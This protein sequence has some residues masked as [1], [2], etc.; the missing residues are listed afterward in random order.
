MHIV[1]N[2][3]LTAADI[4]GRIAELEAELPD[5]AAKITTLANDDPSAVAWSEHH[6]SIERLRAMLAAAEIR[7][8]AA[9]SAAK[10]AERARLRPDAEAAVRAATPE[11]ALAEELAW[12]DEIVGEW[13][14]LTASLPGR[15]AEMQAAQAKALELAPKGGVAFAARVLD[16]SA[17]RALIYD[18]MRRAVFA[19]D[20]SDEAVACSTAI[21]VASRAALDAPPADTFPARR[22]EVA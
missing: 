21:R 6:R 8:A 22:A 2:Q 11:T 5:L 20:L 1:P 14:E 3:P 19:A 15:L 10:K 9:A 7:E 13:M 18:R 16:P 12:V 17:L 4:R